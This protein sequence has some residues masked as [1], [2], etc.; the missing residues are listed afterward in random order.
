M[1]STNREKSLRGNNAHNALESLFENCKKHTYI[2]EFIKDYRV[3]REDYSK[4]QFYAPFLL[5]FE[6]NEK[7][8]IF[9]TTSMRSDRIKGPQW[10]S[11]NLKQIDT[12][13]TKCFLVYPD[14]VKKD[15]FIKQGHK[16][17][18]KVE[19]SAIDNILSQNELDS[20]IEENALKGRT[21]GQI[22][23]LQGV[24]FENKIANILSNKENLKKWKTDT[25]LFVGLH[26]NIFEYIVT[27]FKLDAKLVEKIQ[28]TSKI[29][30]LPSGGQ[31]KTDILVTV[32]YN[33]SS[34]NFT[35]S[36]KRSSSKVVSVHQYSANS[37]SDVLNPKDKE[38]MTLLKI[39]QSYGNLTDFGEKNKTD[40][41][42]YIKPYRKELAY[43]VFGGIGGEGNPEKQ[44]A[45]YLLTLN[46]ESNEISLYS[47]KDYYNKL[48][49][50]G[51]TGHFGT[52]FS[53]TFA[54]GQK[55]KSIQL[56]TKLL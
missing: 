18:N 8:A 31:P 56:K 55:G 23:A 53:W 50:I 42:T 35:I 39:F 22:K 43:W 7:W 15:A 17:T 6:N 25:D 3:G 20:L 51:I 28:A 1:E 29:E 34:S 14:S 38:L 12:S 30:K 4:S 44:W 9:S 16:Y 13:I 48:I 2:R 32:H 40:L 10:D 27:F 5:I 21:S 49:D 45:N 54:S 47:I 36:C 41:T 52:V 46:N 11:Y 24:A 26:Y 37:F 19:F 33:D